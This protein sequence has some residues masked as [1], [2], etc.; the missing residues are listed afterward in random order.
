[1]EVREIS[2][3]ELERSIAKLPP[4]S[5]LFLQSSDW[6]KFQQS[7][8]TQAE[9]LGFWQRDELIGTALA[10][11]RNLP[12]NNYYIY[13]PRGPVVFNTAWW[14]DVLT[15]LVKYYQTA[16]IMFLRVEPA[17]AVPSSSSLATREKT[18]K[19]GTRNE[20]LVASGY[21]KTISVQPA[22]TFIT[23]LHQPEDQLLAAMH[24]KTRYNINLSLKKNLNWN[25]LGAEGLDDFWRLIKDTTAR[26]NFKSHSLAHYKHLLNLFGDKPLDSE[27][28]VRLAVVSFEGRALAASMTVWYGGVVTYLHGASANQERQLMPTYFLHWQ[29]IVEAKKLGF[30]YYDWWG[31][32]TDQHHQSDWQGITRFKKGFGGTEL[33]YLGTFDY[34]YHKFWYLIYRLAR[35]IWRQ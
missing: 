12:L 27:L 18:Q 1:M 22:S 23:D 3:A 6:L 28:A 30:K 2:E 7:L 34:P 33:D 10:L 17:I 35:R 32:N 26:D 14:P 21:T 25:L 4:T 31:I 29:T 16:N 13:V 15:A 24:P 8:G 11:K 5:G 19:R 9:V 20:E